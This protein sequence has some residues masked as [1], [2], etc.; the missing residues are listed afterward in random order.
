ML[1]E[2]VEA[3]ER[4]D[5]MNSLALCLEHLADSPNDP[6]GHLLLANLYY[7]SGCAELAASSV[8][9][10]FRRFPDKLSLQKLLVALNPNL[11]LEELSAA[12]LS[13]ANPSEVNV[14]SSVQGEGDKDKE[15]RESS[16]SVL[17]ESE[18]DFDEL[19]LLEEKDGG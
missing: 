13:K 10:L 9:D 3:R 18:F 14:V 15:L 1:E 6:Q 17:A 7:L 16:D 19:N 11:T 12:N 2:A 4:G 8:M 5:L